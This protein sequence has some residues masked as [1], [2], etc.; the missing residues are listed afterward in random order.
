MRYYIIYL[1][2]VIIIRTLKEKYF[3]TR[4]NFD[5]NI[6]RKGP[7]SGGLSNDSLSANKS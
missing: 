1:I 5:V 7:N 4:T 3:R 6:M 2:R